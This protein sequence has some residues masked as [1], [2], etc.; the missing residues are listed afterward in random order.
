[1]DPCLGDSTNKHREKIDYNVLLFTL[2]KS[3]FVSQ[4]KAAKIP[5]LAFIHSLALAVDSYYSK[6]AP[7]RLEEFFKINYG[8]HS[9]F[10]NDNYEHFIQTVKKI[11]QGADSVKLSTLY[12]KYSE[13]VIEKRENP[14]GQAFLDEIDGESAL[15]EIIFT[16]NSFLDHPIMKTPTF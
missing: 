3:Q 1:M 5:A 15:A 14:F 9:N 7:M 13:N 10:S 16:N 4:A 8:S 2:E 11:Y 6:E 12:I